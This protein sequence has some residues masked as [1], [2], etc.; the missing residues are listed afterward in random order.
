M[1]NS[2]F[3]ALFYDLYV[4]YFS[5]EI[6]CKLEETLIKTICKYVHVLPKVLDIIEVIDTTY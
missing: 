4:Y 6:F 5:Y 1:C 2:F 3:Y